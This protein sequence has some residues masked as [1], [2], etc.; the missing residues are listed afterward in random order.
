MKTDLENDERLMKEGITLYSVRDEV[1]LY[2][3]GG[4]V[5][6]LTRSASV[7]KG[8]G[9]ASTSMKPSFERNMRRYTRGDNVVKDGASEKVALIIYKY[10]FYCFYR[11][12]GF[13][14]I[15]IA[16]ITRSNNR[17]VNWG[18]RSRPFT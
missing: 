7:G 4:S 1:R 14:K 2:E 3:R 16:M 6:K 5:F 8:R 13:L 9:S 10:R 18:N 17:R 11:C 12:C 15:L